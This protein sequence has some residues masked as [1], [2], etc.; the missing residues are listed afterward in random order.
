MKVTAKLR[1]LPHLGLQARLLGAFLVVAVLPLLAFFVVQQQQLQQHLHE[2]AESHVEQLALAQQRRLAHEFRRLSDQLDLIASRTQMR[3]SLAEYLDRGDPAALALVERILGDAA[4]PA[5]NILSIGVRTPDGRVIALD[6]GRAPSAARGNMRTD[7]G[8]WIPAEQPEAPGPGMRLLA[9]DGG[10]VVA[11]LE[12]ELRLGTRPLGWLYVL[13][14]TR[15]LGAILRDYQDADAGGQTLL[16]LEKRGGGPMILEP[17]GGESTELRISGIRLDP[18]VEAAL[19]QGPGPAEAKIVAGTK[20]GLYTL[21]ALPVPGIN[22]VIA[23]AREEFRHFDTGQA[24]ALGLNL[25]ALL[26]L[27]L[28]V[29]MFM[30]ARIARPLRHVS[31]AARRLRSGD[32]SVRVPEE[33]WGELGQLTHAFNVTAEE[34]ARQARDL[35][36]EMR[37]SRRAQ[38]ELADMAGTDHLTGLMN[39][40]R[41]MEVLAAHF[42]PSNPGRGQGAL[43]YLDLDRFKPVND[44]FGHEAGDETLRVVAERLAG[45]VRA[46]DPLARLGGDEFAIF[47]REPLPV[48]EVYALAERITDA[49]SRPISVCGQTVEV[50]C[51]VGVAIV[52]PGSSREELLYRADRDMYRVK[53]ARSAAQEESR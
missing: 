33:G 24:R 4:A 28:V 14:D 49:L 47:I 39:R 48:E 10:E 51:S 13:S 36:E 23:V 38:R 53:A 11:R 5:D 37:R 16:L 18:A 41:L 43:L 42:D 1:W 20:G 35:E 12:R 29:A 27:A 50:G 31:E 9:R 19:L 22:V 8:S 26:L 17:A 45:L 32:S 21:R 25:V 34:L 52:E 3:I 46:N 44:L 2:H 40:R 7:E 6:D 30:A 15:D